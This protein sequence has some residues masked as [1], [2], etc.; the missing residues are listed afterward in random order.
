MTPV[1][2]PSGVN[3]LKWE[4]QIPIMPGDVAFFSLGNVTANDLTAYFSDSLVV[5]RLLRGGSPF[6][7]M[8]ELAEKPSK[9]ESQAA[10]L[11][12]RNSLVAGR[13]DS[14][15]EIV[16]NGISNA[17]KDYYE[18]AFANKMVTI[19]LAKNEIMTP[20]IKDPN[21]W[22]FDTEVMVYSGLYW[23]TNWKST[24]DELNSLTITAS[25]RGGT[26]NDIYPLAV[27][28]Y[29]PPPPSPGEG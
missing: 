21:A 7:Q 22:D 2:L 29:T 11:A 17:Q 16:L 8:G 15:A 9:T 1:T 27:P 5:A 4:N 13:R 3:D 6:I 25:L 26:E 14:T 20:D 10:R 18:N 19:I 24:S 28:A 23:K 12:T